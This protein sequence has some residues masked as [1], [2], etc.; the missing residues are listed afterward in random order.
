MCLSSDFL[1]FVLHSH[2]WLTSF[3]IRGK[4]H[5]QGE[6]YNS[7]H[8]IRHIMLVGLDVLIVCLGKLWRYF[9]YS[10]AATNYSIVLVL[11]LLRWLWTVFWKDLLKFIFTI[12]FPFR[13]SGKYIQIVPLTSPFKRMCCPIP[14]GMKLSALTSH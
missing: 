5:K 8:F 14:H 4:I 1:T 12:L 3:T 11:A 7:S 13:Y 10:T 2:T 9:V 6:I